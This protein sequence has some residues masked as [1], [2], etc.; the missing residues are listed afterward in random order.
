MS[1][2]SWKLRWRVEARDLIAASPDAWLC[3]DDPPGITVEVVDTWATALAMDPGAIR[4]LARQP[5]PPGALS[6]AWATLQDELGARRSWRL[7]ASVDGQPAAVGD[8]RLVP[9]PDSLARPPGATAARLSGAVT[10]PAHRGRGLFTTMVAARCCIAAAHG[11]TVALTHAREDTSA[12]IL[13][14]LGSVPVALERCWVLPTA[15]YDSIPP[16][17]ADR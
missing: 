4:R 13:E 1:W 5:T 14:R 2:S 7:L 6:E 9:L 3:A 8:C 11:A 17:T 15:N 16:P 12:P 10:L